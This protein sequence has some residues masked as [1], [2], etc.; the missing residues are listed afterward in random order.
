MNAMWTYFWPVF[1]VGL[2]AGAAA[3][4][5]AFRRRS[6]RNLL[7]AAGL[8]AALAA[9]ALWH[10]PFGGAGRFTAEI[11]RS[12]RQGLDNYEM[13][14]ISARLH[15]DP[16]ARRLVLSGPADDF[17]RR[18]LV[19]IMGSIPGVRT[20]TWSGKNGGR[21]LIVESMVVAV[22]GFLSG[23]VLAYLVALRRRYNEQWSW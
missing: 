12:A 8:A 10:G 2:I 17:Q 6:K 18:E 5:I 7:L 15:R 22:L 4:S 1:A 13:A 16:L 21:P 19:R 20:A 3:E 11:E 14:G 23:L 9:T